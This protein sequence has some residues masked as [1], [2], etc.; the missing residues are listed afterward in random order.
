[1]ICEK[2]YQSEICWEFSEEK[3]IPC[4]SFTYPHLQIQICPIWCKI[5][6][7]ATKTRML[8]RMYLEFFSTP[9][10]VN[11]EIKVKNNKQRNVWNKNSRIGPR[12]PAYFEI[13]DWPEKWGREK[14]VG[15][16]RDV[17]KNMQSPGGGFP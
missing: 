5:S 9:F 10:S 13:E 7:K 17:E 14:S 1:M 6:A 4:H 12:H 8:A 11:K 16:G 15:V 3:V 2:V